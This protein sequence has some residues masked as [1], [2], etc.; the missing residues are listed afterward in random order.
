M[1][2]Q[3]FAFPVCFLSSLLALL[4]THQTGGSSGSADTVEAG[5]SGGVG[6]TVW[7]LQCAAHGPSAGAGAAVWVL[8]HVQPSDVSGWIKH[9]SSASLQD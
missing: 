7:Q 6:G 3:D 1:V 5:T 8:T 9:D 2:R 4:K